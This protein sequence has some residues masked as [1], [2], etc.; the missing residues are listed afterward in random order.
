MSASSPPS[1]PDRRLH[2]FG[3]MRAEDSGSAIDVPA[4]NAQRLL[5]YLAL[6][7]GVPHRREA[8][9]DVL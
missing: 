2:V 8:V 7:A 6:R 4:G 5:A 9:A 1:A 3:P